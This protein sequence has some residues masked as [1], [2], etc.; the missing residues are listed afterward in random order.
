MPGLDPGIQSL[1]DIKKLDCRIKSD[2][3]SALGESRFAKLGFRQ[4]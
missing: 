1:T 4:S 3:D 2:N